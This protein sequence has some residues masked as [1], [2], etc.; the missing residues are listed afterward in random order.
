MP[1]RLTEEELVSLRDKATKAAC[2]SWQTA[3]VGGE[4][5]VGYAVPTTRQYSLEKERQYGLRRKVP[6]PEPPIYT[7]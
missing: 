1:E 4:I 3:V 7:E 6:E 2:D 5:V